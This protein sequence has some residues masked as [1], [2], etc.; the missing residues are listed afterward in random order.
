M[1]ECSEVEKTKFWRNILPLSSRC[2]TPG[3]ARG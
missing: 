1:P 2:D 3:Y